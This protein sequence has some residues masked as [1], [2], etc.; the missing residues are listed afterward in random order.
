MLHQV[1]TAALAASPATPLCVAFSG[2][3]D[4][5]A[6]LHALAQLPE[7][8][9]RGL[10]ALHV[11]HGLQADS[12]KW[13]RHCQAFCGSLGVSLTCLRVTVNDTH[14]E[15]VE[16]AARHARHAAFA[17]E[18][19]AGEWLAL[20]HHRDDQI[21][22]ILLKLLRGAGPEGL[23]GMRPLRPF[24]HGCLWRPLLDVPRS[25]LREYVAT[26]DL[27][28]IDDPANTDPRFARNVLRNEILPRMAHHWPHA[29]ASILHAATLCRTA[30]DHLAHDAQGALSSLRHADSTLD[31]DGWL[32]LP[33]ALRTPVLLCW[34]HE[35]GLPAPTDAQRREL[36]R[37][38]AR[39]AEDALPRIAWPGAEVRVWNERLHAMPPLAM[40]PA[41]WFAG[42]DGA[43][44]QLPPGCGTLAL[45]AT[46]EGSPPPRTTGFDVP[47]VVRFRHG[48]ERIKPV[49]DPHTRELRDLFQQACIPPWIR[50]RCPLIYAQDQLIAIADLWTS[51][52][53][54]NVFAS[55][56]AKPR[57]LPEKH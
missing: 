21:E 20:A 39:A 49:G 45:Q 48:G 51:Q 28:C 57:W 18:L 3:P 34:L 36:E 26:N 7:A 23:G 35:L 27:P 5:T 12:E 14:G 16:A 1:L 56:G 19:R 10:R 33:E 47:L 30:A 15:G 55:A 40:P 32:A 46:A 31:A 6:L 38:T 53:G 8:R 17:G 54:E 9:K 43:A 29:G 37:Q 11:D 4:S 50:E 24:A 52:A 42:W 2:G 25:A 13:A 41:D 44:L 22:T